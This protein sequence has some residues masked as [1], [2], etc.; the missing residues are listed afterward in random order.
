MPAAAALLLALG[1]GCGAFGAH[2]LRGS[3]PHEDLLIW[4]KSVLY[5]LLHGLGA[6]VIGGLPATVLSTGSRARIAALMLLSL[7]IFSGSLY[8]LVLT[9]VRWLGAIT[10]VG[11]LGLIVSWLA[12]SFQLLKGRH[13][14]E[15]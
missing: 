1:V 12:L 4:E 5:H 13:I 8:A 3:V 7:L 2:A 9:G 10:P 14:P 15:N 6:L 11:G